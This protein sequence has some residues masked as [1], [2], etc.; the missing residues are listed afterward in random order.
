MN[1]PQSK[2]SAS[3]YGGGS[4]IYGGSI[5]T[6]NHGFYGNNPNG[7]VSKAVQFVCTDDTGHYVISKE[8]RRI[9]ERSI[10]K[11]AIICIAGGVASG[12]SYL[13]NQLIEVQGAFAVGGVDSEASSKQKSEKENKA[14]YASKN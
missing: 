11:V 7:S 6:N 12:K 3:Y 2:Y 10:N 9:F 5:F 1:S 14:S 4:S 13:M 8:A